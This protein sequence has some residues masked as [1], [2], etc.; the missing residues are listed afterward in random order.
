M[1]WNS[2]AIATMILSYGNVRR[3]SD[4][5]NRFPKGKSKYQFSGLRQM[6]S[7]VGCAEFRLPM[8]WF[9]LFEPFVMDNGHTMVPSIDVRAP[10][11]THFAAF[12]S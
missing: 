11:N 5:C 9:V 7:Y 1:I 2:C 3:A 10:S 6:I 8:F 4:I 12:L